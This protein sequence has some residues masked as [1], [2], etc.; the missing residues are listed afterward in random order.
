MYLEL[1]GEIRRIEMSVNTKATY[2]IVSTTEIRRR[3][4]N[5]LGTENFKDIPSFTNLVALIN[6]RNDMGQSIRQRGHTMV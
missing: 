1:Q 4:H 5:S 2:M 3:P 6:S